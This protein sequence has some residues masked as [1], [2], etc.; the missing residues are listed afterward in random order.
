MSLKTF[1][2][3]RIMQ[4]LTGE[5][6]LQKRREEFERRRAH[7]PH[8]ISYYHQVDDP[9]S[10]L[11]LQ[12]LAAVAARYDVVVVPHLVGPPADWAAPERDRLQAWARVDA[13][14]LAAR[15]GLTFPGGDAQPQPADVR[16]ANASLLPWLGSDH[17]FDHAYETGERLWLGIDLPPCEEAGVDEALAAGE[18]RREADG[19]FMSGMIHYGGEWYWGVDRLHYLERRLTGLDADAGE[20]E[21]LFPCPMEGETGPT[22]SERG[23]TVEF[24]MSFR[25]PYTYLA[26]ARA[27]RMAERCGAKFVIREVLPMVMRG[28]PVPRMKG[29][30]FAQDAAREARRMGIPFGR[31]ADPVGRP[32]ERGYS[33]LGLARERGCE[34]DYCQSFMQA[35]WAEG[36][37]AG[38][39]EGLRLIVE[40][41]GLDWAEARSCIGNDQWRA[42]AEANRE[43]MFALGHWGVPCIRAG[44]VAV[45]G[46]DR[47]WVI[48]DELRR[49]PV[50]FPQ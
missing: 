23:A 7:G 8:V 14:L 10:H 43:V 20:G 34:F 19:H 3:S 27:K 12:A 15:H 33:L 49:I 50:P 45:W 47:L 41:A 11:A 13:R 44:K 4:S 39:D 16:L 21:P 18:A 26:L 22:S 48:E 36:V 37:D 42:G 28:L 40:R 2:T 17:F 6:R 1:V 46:Q 24:F 29:L 9:W 31:I 30:Y 25:S 32:V 35:V 38:S 5:E